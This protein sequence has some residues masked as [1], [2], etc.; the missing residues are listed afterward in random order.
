MWPLLSLPPSHTREQP[1][2]LSAMKALATPAH[3]A[4]NTAAP[5][6]TASP[7]LVVCRP[8]R[9]STTHQIQ[10]R[11]QGLASHAS[12]S[13]LEK[14][15]ALE[16]AQQMLHKP[17]TL[18]ANSD[19]TPLQLRTPDK[20]HKTASPDNLRPSARVSFPAQSLTAHQ[21]WPP[22][23]STRGC[24]CFRL[25]RCRCCFDCH[26][27]VQ[28]A[29]DASTLCLQ[30]FNH[31]CRQPQDK[32]ISGFLAGHHM[33]CLTRRA[34]ISPQPLLSTAGSTDH[35]YSK[36]PIWQ[37]ACA[38]LHAI[39]LWHASAALFV[40]SSKS[41]VLPSTSVSRSAV[42]A[43]SRPCFSALH[44]RNHSATSCSQAHTCRLGHKGHRRTVLLC[45]Y[46][47]KAVIS[48]RCVSPLPF[49]LPQGFP[50]LLGG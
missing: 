12:C 1:L 29:A 6:K 30:V 13:R 23:A 20:Q 22:A 21:C 37:V 41:P 38:V 32:D 3:A 17:C 36:H 26:N 31:R 27:V 44:L 28:H 11:M 14:G 46:H 9:T 50:C 40:S 45:K 43:T 34:L 18:P 5:M 2:M 49:A 24:L 4:T 35:W 25:C 47:N 8:C 48:Q 7:S 16:Q 10:Y 39:Q 15:R 19:R 33:T 42:S